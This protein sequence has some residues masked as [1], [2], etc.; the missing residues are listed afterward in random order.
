MT[1][2]TWKTLLDYLELRGRLGAFLEEPYRGVECEVRFGEVLKDPF[3]VT[4]GLR[5]GC[6]R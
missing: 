2:W 5:Q 3:E 4:M 6:V 1:L